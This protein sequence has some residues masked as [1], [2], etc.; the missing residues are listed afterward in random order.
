MSIELRASERIAAKPGA[1]TPT[2]TGTLARSTTRLMIARLSSASS[3]GASPMIPR[4]V[5]PVQPLSS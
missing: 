4:M 1:E 2:M 3:F 5:M